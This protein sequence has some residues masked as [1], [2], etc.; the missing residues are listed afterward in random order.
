M[1]ET[2]DGD[3]NVVADAP[4]RV[5]INQRRRGEALAFT[6]PYRMLP[7]IELAPTFEPAAPEYA[8]TPTPLA[9]FDPSK[10]T[11]DQT[12]QNAIDSIRSNFQNLPTTVP[13]G[14]TTQVQFND[15]GVFG[16]DAGLVYTKATDTLGI[17]S[18]LNAP[19]I[20]ATTVNISGQFVMQGGVMYPTPSTGAI[21]VAS[22][23]HK[24]E[25][26]NAGTA[27]DAAMIAFHRVGTFA[28]VFGIDTDNT[29]RVGG[30]SM[31]TYSYRLLHEGNSFAI[32]TS[33]NL[34][35][36]THTLYGTGYV[37]AGAVIG[38][39]LYMGAQGGAALDFRVHQTFG[40]TA[41]STIASMVASVGQVCRILVNGNGSVALPASLKWSDGSPVWGSVTTF[42]NMWTD[43]SI[44]WASTTPFNV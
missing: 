44:F 36:A 11:I 41:G 40:V 15:A 6:S 1:S 25:V 17:G 10:P 14:G 9:A 39:Y 24:L 22:P 18:T 38:S 35:F 19:T 33:A 23:G 20:N 4:R 13:G 2:F 16:G 34:N 7:T 42:I 30:W 27:G 26:R 21:A 8:L 37:S 32:D 28:A 12:R 31:G 3:G 43:G 5:V 29:W